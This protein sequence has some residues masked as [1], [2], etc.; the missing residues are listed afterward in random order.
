MN[1][2]IPI[3]I[4]LLVL[5]FIGFKMN[6]IRTKMA[7]FFILFGVFAVLFITFLL[8]S[9]ENF[10]F[11]SGKRLHTIWTPGAFGL[12]PP[13]LWQLDFEKKKV[14]RRTS[15][16]LL[17]NPEKPIELTFDGRVYWMVSDNG[18]TPLVRALTRT[19][20]SLRSYNVFNNH[21][22]VTFNGKYLMLLEE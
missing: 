1:I 14:I 3:A 21:D 5:I 20:E 22:G 4:I 17:A 9:G 15:Y 19:G 12:R 2:L 11:S 10:D 6:N 8:I 7:F 18:L 16:S 13:E